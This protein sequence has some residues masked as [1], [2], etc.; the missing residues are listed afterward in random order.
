MAVLN[1]S[2]R[3]QVHRGLMRFWS[4]SHD[5]ISLSKSELR[6][7]IDDTDDWIDTNQASYVAALSAATQAALSPAQKT[8]LFCAVAAMR[9]STNFAKRLVGEV[10]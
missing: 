4:K 5:V 3:Q 9:V 2:E 10:D 7:A 8:L 1:E 6:T